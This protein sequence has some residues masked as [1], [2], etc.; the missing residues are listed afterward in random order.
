VKRRQQQLAALHESTV[1]VLVVGAGFNGTVAASALAGTGRSVALIDRGDFASFTS[2]QSS[3]LAWGGF[4]YL[5][6]YEIPL[7]M[8]LC[9]SRNRL[10]REYP[11]AISEVRFWAT[12]D[13][14]APFPP[15]LAALG[16]AA[17]WALGRFATKAPRFHRP[18]A[19]KR[20]EPVIRIDTAKAA[21]EYSDAY[22]KDNDARFAWNFVRQALH[23]HANHTTAVNYVELVGAEY[24]DNQWQVELHD[25]APGPQDHVSHT[26]SRL[27]QDP[28]RLRCKAI[29]NAAGPFADDL[30]QLLKAETEHRIVYSKGIHLVVPRITDHER[31][32]AF[33]D[34]SRRLFFVIPMAHRSVIGTTDTRTDNPYEP[35]TDEDRHFVLDQVNARLDLATPLTLGDVISERSGVRPLVVRDDGVDY[36]SIDWTSLS[37]KHAIEVDEDRKVVSIMGGKLTDCIN[38]GEEVIEAIKSRRWFTTPERH[39]A[40][41]EGGGHWYGEGS[42]EERQQ[43]LHAAKAVGLDRKPSVEREPSMAAVLWRRHGSLAYEVVDALASDPRQGEEVLA[44]SDILRGE[45]PLYAEYEM[46]VTLEDF[47]RRRTKLAMIHRATDLANDPGLAEVCDHLGV[48]TPHS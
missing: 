46:V 24:H 47:L 12:L 39:D 10:M 15:W 30:N 28:I 35:I 23:Q 48:A 38:V 40:S 44:D 34:D 19:L 27:P 3:N 5:E 11:S 7:V 42:A 36:D 29:V 2:Q 13:T 6:N 32:L 45:L 1:D 33:F 9:R 20:H 41:C 18:Q 16:S 21:V 31:V 43:F 17:Y 25:R 22:F 4:K 8:K 26:D 14:T 37:R